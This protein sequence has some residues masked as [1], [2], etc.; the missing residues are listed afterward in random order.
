MEQMLRM[1]RVAGEAVTGGANVFLLWRFWMVAYGLIGLPLYLLQRRKSGE[2]S[3]SAESLREEQEALT[4]ALREQAGEDSIDTP[5]AA[6]AEAEAEAEANA[7]ERPQ[8]PREEQ[9][10]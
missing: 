8:A 7:R 10:R 5:T 6:D 9:T 1:T 3:L 4:A 2:E